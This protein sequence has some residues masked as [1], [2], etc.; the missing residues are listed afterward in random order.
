MSVRRLAVIVMLFV[1]PAASAFALQATEVFKLSVPSV[2]VLEFS[3]D[4]WRT[5]TSGTGFIVAPN[6]VATSY[7][8]IETLLPR[9]IVGRALLSN[10]NAYLAVTV[11]LSDPIR[12]LMVVG[13]RECPVRC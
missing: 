7:H 8:L 10:S 6:V 3:D 1:L 4:N 13:F 12:D 5:R 2:V 11:L 9:D